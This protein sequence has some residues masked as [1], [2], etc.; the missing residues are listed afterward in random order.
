MN[1]KSILSVC[2]LATLAVS[3]NCS[4]DSKKKSNE[5]SARIEPATT[6]ILVSALAPVVVNLLQGL[7]GHIFSP[8]DY[9]D[10]VIYG[11]SM[12]LKM[13]GED[14]AQLTD[15]ASGITEV[16]HGSNTQEA[17]GD[18][19]K[20]M[21]DELISRNLL[22]LNDLCHLHITFPH[23]N[24]ETCPGVI[25]NPCDLYHPVKTTPTP[26]HNQHGD[27]YCERYSY[28][29]DQPQFHTFMRQYCLKTCS[30]GTC[31]FDT[32]PVDPCK[33]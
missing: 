32:A 12:R 15:R 10:T 4:K 7:V 22:S 8:S 3:I 24:Q 2:V 16:G 19:T 18:A 20:K 28:R 33:V 14:C 6:A 5:V 25:I 27:A 26:C 31:S 13:C 21:F 30:K 1:F 23:P 29:C 11:R 9:Q 17:L